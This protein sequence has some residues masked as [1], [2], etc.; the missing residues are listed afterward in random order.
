MMTMT[1]MNEGRGK[2]DRL[3]DYDKKKMGLN[4]FIGSIR[5]IA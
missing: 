1:M 3:S 2:L 5:D 4:G